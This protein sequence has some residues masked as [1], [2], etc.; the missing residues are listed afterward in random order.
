MFLQ[1][2]KAAFNKTE[3]EPKVIL[4]RSEYQ[5]NLALLNAPNPEINTT[6]FANFNS[7]VTFPITVDEKS[8][9]ASIRASI[10][11]NPESSFLVSLTLKAVQTYTL[12]CTAHG[13]SCQQEPNNLTPYLSPLAAEA[14]NATFAFSGYLGNGVI[15]ENLTLC[16]LNNT[17]CTEGL[18]TVGAVSNLTENNWNLFAPG[19]AGVIGFGSQSPVWDLFPGQDT[20]WL[21]VQFEHKN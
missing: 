13:T 20:Y 2:F 14:Q 12:D 15:A 11:F 1:N 4:L 10:D 18:T 19:Y 17:A 7:P 5:Q 9:Q 21:L 8:L 6:P 3:S 16:F